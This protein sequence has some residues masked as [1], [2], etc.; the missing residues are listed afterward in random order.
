MGTPSR[1]ERRFVGPGLDPVVTGPR[2]G[3]L[4]DRRG[5]GARGPLALP[6]PLSPTS[7]PL[8]RAPRDAFDRLVADVL[9]A[10]EPH[11]VR[12]TDDVD[13]VVEEAPLLPPEWD[14]RVPTSVVAQHLTPARLVLYRLPLASGCET[15]A[16]LEDAVWDAVLDGLAQVWHVPPESL[17]PR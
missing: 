8:H 7:V 14:E 9:A 5:R 15:R 13:V 1:D 10:L 12:E 16:D 11:F 3:R 17:D 2:P 4:R 6:G